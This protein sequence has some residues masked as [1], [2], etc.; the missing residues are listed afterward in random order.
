MMLAYLV[1]LTQY[2]SQSRYHTSVQF[3]NRIDSGPNMVEFILYDGTECV[4]L[5]FYDHE[6]QTAC[7][8]RVRAILDILRNENDSLS[9]I[10]QNLYEIQ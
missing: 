1:T 3:M 7:R 2:L 10:M 9:V 4:I 6:E 8:E 5:T